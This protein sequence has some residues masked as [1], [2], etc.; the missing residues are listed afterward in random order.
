MKETIKIKPKLKIRVLHKPE[1]VIDSKKRKR[2]RRQNRKK[3][4]IKEIEEQTKEE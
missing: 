1:R 3:R 2:E 4:L